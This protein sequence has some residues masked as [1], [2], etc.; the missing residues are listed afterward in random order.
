MIQKLSWP[1]SWRARRPI[2]Y[3]TQLVRYPMEFQAQWGCFDF[4]YSVYLVA[5][6]ELQE[7]VAEELTVLPAAECHS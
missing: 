1:I 5:E 7:V 2:L 6:E 4:D 3:R